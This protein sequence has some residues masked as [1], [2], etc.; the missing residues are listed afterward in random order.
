MVSIT[1]SASSYFVSMWF[2]VKE[3]SCWLA[4]P[5]RLVLFESWQLM[6]LPREIVRWFGV[7]TLNSSFVV[8]LGNIQF[9]QPSGLVVKDGNV[10]LH[11]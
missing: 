10:V 9:L 3:D 1:Y 6:C 8:F 7:T 11:G 5:F 4:S 2:E